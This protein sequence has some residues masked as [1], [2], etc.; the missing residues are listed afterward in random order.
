MKRRKTKKRKLVAS[1]KNGAPVYRLI[2]T[3][4][5]KERRELMRKMGLTYED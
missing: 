4:T 1:D 3:G 5:K 2:F